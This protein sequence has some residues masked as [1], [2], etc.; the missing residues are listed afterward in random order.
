MLLLD[1][2]DVS[3]AYE[4]RVVLAGVSL[5]VKAGERVALTGP[6]GSGKTTLLNCLGG[7]DRVDGGELLFEGR[8]MNAMGGD[9]LAQLRR[10]RMGTIFQFFHLLP[11]LTAAENIEFPLHLNGVGK[12]EREERV[13][14][15]MERVGIGH[16][17][18]ALPSQLSGGE[19][20]RVAIARALAH[21]PGL[22]LADEPTGNLDSANGANIL[23]LLRELSD[24]SGTAL[25]LV[26]HSDEATRICDR[27][28]KLRDGRIVGEERG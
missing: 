11:T 20:Q 14:K 15:L 3:K 25:V 5:S 21:R 28:L 8:A 7:V 24:E 23:A 16:R 19:M 6:S 9:E 18:R 4:D 1:A 27:V 13:A 26:T 22:L 10:S 2:R 17:A 12:A